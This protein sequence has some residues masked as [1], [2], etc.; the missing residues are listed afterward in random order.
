MIAYGMDSQVYQKA[1]AQAL[2]RSS[3]GEV[4]MSAFKVGLT[5]TF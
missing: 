4:N 3:N 2:P 5:R 1:L